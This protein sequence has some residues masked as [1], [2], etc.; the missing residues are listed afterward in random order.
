MEWARCRMMCRG[1]AS[2][3]PEWLDIEIRVTV[4]GGAASLRYLLN[5]SAWVPVRAR[6]T[7]VSVVL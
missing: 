1:R 5:R 6:S 3:V 7:S 4:T 2:S